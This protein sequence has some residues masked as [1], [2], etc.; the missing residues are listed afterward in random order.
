MIK[1][2]QFLVGSA[3]VI[4]LVVVAVLLYR[5]TNMLM[6]HFRNLNQDIHSI[7]NFLSSK[8][9][10]SN[11]VGAGSGIAI[12]AS[13][14]NVEE[15][16]TQINSAQNNIE[17]LTRE[18]AEIQ[19]MMSSS[20]SETDESVNE[21]DFDIESVNLEKVN[22]GELGDTEEEDLQIELTNEENLESYDL[23]AVDQNSE[24][25]NLLSP[26]LNG[27]NDSDKS[28]EQNSIEMAEESKEI[29]IDNESNSIKAEIT[30]DLII[31]RY[32]KKEL[33]N[34]CSLKYISK[35]GNK[36]VL[37]KR[38]LD[39]NYDFGSTIISSGQTVSQN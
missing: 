32:T 39:N 8:M 33:E 11:N 38:L 27:G 35:S 25:E 3:C 2:I 23:A 4:G 5:R 10:P 12:S 24:L 34:L 16:E 26:D 37:V 21:S 29:S 1:N 18:I 22:D 19:D 28:T 36:A 30:E 20:E 6:S 17:K 7:K 14:S 9:T 13:N 31:N 15:A